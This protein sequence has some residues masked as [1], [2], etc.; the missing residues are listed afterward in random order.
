MKSKTA[1]D[2][3]IELTMAFAQSVDSEPPTVP[4]SLPT[5]PQHLMEQVDQA[6]PP[7]PKTMEP[8]VA[9]VPLKH[10]SEREEIQQRVAS[11]KSHQQQLAQAR[12]T[13][14]LQMQA[15]TR[16]LLEVRWEGRGTW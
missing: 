3:L 8:R 2:H 5:A 10:L 13:Y 12:E 16:A 7:P 11:F 1:R 4:Q 14:Y 6:Q 9:S 15:R